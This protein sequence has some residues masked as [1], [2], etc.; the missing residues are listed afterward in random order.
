MSCQSNHLGWAKKG[1]L[2]LGYIEPPPP[3]VFSDVPEPQ[4]QY[5]IWIFQK[6]FFLLHYTLCGP[7]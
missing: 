6:K 2:R 7:L 1:Y 4:C 3:P 5:G